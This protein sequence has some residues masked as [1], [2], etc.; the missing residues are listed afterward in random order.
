MRE[1]ALSKG[2]WDGK[3][4]F[5]FAT[6]YSFLTTARIESAGTRYCEGKSLLEKRNG[7]FS[8]TSLYR[9]NFGN[10][11]RGFM[12]VFFFLKATLLQRQ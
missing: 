10:V 12:V 7:W 9:K 6:V 1:Y 2:W 8:P 3:S 11:D 5:N 4:E